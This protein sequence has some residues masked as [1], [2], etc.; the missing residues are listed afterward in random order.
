MNCAN[1][2]FMQNT[3]TKYSLPNGLLVL[4]KEIHTAPLISHWLWYRVGS[5]DESPGKTGLSHW[6]EHMQFKGTP[7]HPANETDK[8]IS[9]VGGYW[10]AFTYLDWT[11]YFETM[12]ADTI[13]LALEVESDRMTN[14]IYD[15]KE[16]E[17][18][19]TVVLSEMQ[20]NENQPLF[21]LGKAIQAAAF[22]VHPYHHIVIGEEE[23]IRNATRDDLFNH[24][25][26]FYTPNNAV[27]VV[28]GDFETKSM[29]QMIKKY[30]SAIPQRTLPAKHISPEP[31]LSGE[32]KVTIRGTDNT[33][34]IRL[35]YRVPGGAAPDFFPL[36]VLDSLL[37]GPS[38]LN[39]FG[40]GI[41]NRTSR[42]YISL[43]EK[44][45]AVNVSGGLQATIDP[46]IYSISIIG[47]PAHTP[48][49]IIAA[50]DREIKTLQDNLTNQEELNRAVK[51]A[52]ALFAYGSES[53][54]NQAFWMGFSEMFQ[55]YSWFTSYL[56]RLSAVTP[57]DIQQMAQKYLRPENRVVG[58][59]LPKN[60]Q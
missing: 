17:S 51:Q 7:D 31:A 55:S 1:I 9:R 43:V 34:Y 37:T 29:Q 36:N 44:E 19:R 54:T 45:L 27:L 2:L 11:T 58:I 32:Q 5:R 49:E 38:N 42:L 16:V 41:S 12:P 10:N 40:G 50:V 53:I 46:F 21:K 59:Y 25:K 60:G 39:M 56:D 48:E 57:S 8:A 26:T 15:A 13:K 3:F 6:V 24:Y 47:H 28:A 14:S 33:M 4:L 52:R 30:Y 18:E 23:D 22:R 20:G 35:A